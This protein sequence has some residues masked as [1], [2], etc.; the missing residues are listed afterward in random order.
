MKYSTQLIFAL[1]PFTF[2]AVSL[3]GAP[4][5]SPI[6]SK[7]PAKVTKRPITIIQSEMSEK[8][9]MAIIK[10]I[11]QKLDSF[12]NVHSAPVQAE[13]FDEIGADGVPLEPE[14]P[15][16]MR[17]QEEVL[18]IVLNQVKKLYPQSPSAIEKEIVERMTKDLP[19][20][21]VGQ[22]TEIRYVKGNR[23]YKKKDK[24]G[25]FIDNGAK[26]K[27]GYDAIAIQDV[28]AEDQLRLVPEKLKEHI[29]QVAQEEKNRA[30]TEMLKF[31][32]KSIT[33]IRD[34]IEQRNERLGYIWDQNTWK[35][36]KQY[37]LGI[38]A[39]KPVI[40]EE[41]VVEKPATVSDTERFA[42]ARK[43]MIEDA[44]RSIR[45][46][47]ML[48][49]T[50]LDAI[51]GI[52]GLPWLVSYETANAA[53]SG[54]PDYLQKGPTLSFNLSE[55]QETLPFKG[56]VDAQFYNGHF[57]SFKLILTP[58]DRHEARAVF[59]QFVNKFGQPSLQAVEFADSELTYEWLGPKKQVRAVMHY[60]PGPESSV[61]CLDVTFS[62]N[63]GVQL[64][65]DKFRKQD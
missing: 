40:E 36:A 43:K 55:Q 49:Y 20:I 58:N 31:R 63:N 19:P 5:P 28:V 18:A 21:S 65:N 30:R 7:A 23:T 4:S 10:I 9:K 46:W 22:E 44:N 51:H 25:G 45:A 41:I 53:A 32:S 37:A 57:L 27:M 62:R 59:E 24:F 8:R 2:S 39:Q 15:A 47:G 61:K 50:G 3:I 11:D 17:S 12:R 26:I 60:V 34:G 48:R 16:D 42:E 33:E 64:I 54:Y 13:I 38:I 14:T 56:P 29:A 1:L 6:P 35:T 52:K